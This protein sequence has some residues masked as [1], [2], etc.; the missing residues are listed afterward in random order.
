MDYNALIEHFL[1]NH[2]YYHKKILKF[3]KN[4]FLK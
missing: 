2:I 4:Y 1:W 3:E